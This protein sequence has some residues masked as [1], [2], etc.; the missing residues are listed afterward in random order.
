[1]VHPVAPESSSQK[2]VNV[3]VSY[4]AYVEGAVDLVATPVELPRE[5]VIPLN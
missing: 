5:F 2:G 1:M 4:H 3:G